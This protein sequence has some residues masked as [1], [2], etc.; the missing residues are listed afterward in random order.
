MATKELTVARQVE[1]DTTAT[2]NEKI[3]KTGSARHKRLLEKAKQFQGATWD[4]S[5]EAHETEMHK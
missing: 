1:V 5:L 3:Y 2:L 4:A